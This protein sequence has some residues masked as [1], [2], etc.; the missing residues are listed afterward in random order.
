VERAGLGDSHLLWK[1]TRSDDVDLFREAQRLIGGAAGQRMGE[2]GVMA[3]LADAEGNLLGANRAF[4]ARA[5]GQPDLAV[6]GTPLVSL[7]AVTEEGSST[8]PASRA[9]RRRS[10]SSRS[11]SPR[12]PI[13]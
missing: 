8:S 7:I 2:A 3:A 4:I 10:A 6:S 11:P 1:F 9:A 12:A 5:M 13:R